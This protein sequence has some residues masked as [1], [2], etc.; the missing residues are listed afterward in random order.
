MGKYT[1]PEVT[2]ADV[3][4]ALPPIVPPLSLAVAVRPMR[5]NPSLVHACVELAHADAYG[6]MRV[7]SRWG[8]DVRAA[9]QKDVM[10]AL[11]LAAQ[12]CWLYVEGRDPDELLS[13]IAWQLGVPR[14]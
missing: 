13:F 3:V 8:R 1:P 10:R 9:S 2:M 11:L 12:E 14:T 5:S 6:A 4:A 7:Y